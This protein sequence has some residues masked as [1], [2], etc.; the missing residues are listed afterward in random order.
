MPITI[1]EAKKE[2]R[3]KAFDSLA[4]YKFIMFGYHAAIWIT[5]NKLDTKKEPNPFVRLVN[6]ARETKDETEDTTVESKTFELGGQ[7]YEEVQ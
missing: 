3:S 4:R 5:L 7:T 6:L 1:E 2:A